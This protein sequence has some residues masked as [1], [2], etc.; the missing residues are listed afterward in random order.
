MPSKSDFFTGREAILNALH[1][2]LKQTGKAALKQAISGLGGIGKTQTAI[3]YAEKFQDEYTFIL[4]AQ[5]ENESSLLDSYGVF[6]NKLGLPQNPNLAERIHYVKA[7]LGREKGWLL[8]CD[9]ADIPELVIQFLPRRFE[10]RVLITS[11]AQIFDTVGITTPVN[12]D[13]LDPDEALDFLKLRTGR[14]TLTDE[15]KQAAQTI[16]EE[17]GYLPLA[18]EQA[19][20]YI[21]AK[22]TFSGYLGILRQQMMKV[23]KGTKPVAGNYKETVATTWLINFQEV[24]TNSSAAVDILRLCAFLAPN[25]IPI[26]LLKNGADQISLAVVEA[27]Q[28]SFTPN[29][30]LEPL[31]KYSLIRFDQKT[32]TFMV[33]RLVQEVIRDGLDEPSQHQWA[34]KTIRLLDQAFPSPETQITLDY[35]DL[36]SLHVIRVSEWINRFGIHSEEAG[37]L[38]NNVGGYLQ[39]MGR[40]GTAEPLCIQAFAIAEK[41]FGPKH[42]NTATALNNIALLKIHKGDLQEVEQLLF[43]AQ[44]IYI[45]QFGS[46][47]HYVARVQSNLASL[48]H[49][50]G[51]FLEAKSIHETVLKTRMKNL[52]PN[53]LET[54]KTLNNLATTLQ[55]L[56]ELTEAEPKFQ[57]VFEIRQTLL[58]KTHPDT[59]ATLINLAIVYHD[60]GKMKEA[61]QLCNQAL[62]IIEVYLPNHPILANLLM[63]LAPIRITQNRVSEAE[64]LYKQAY[65]T[66]KTALSDQHPH[67]QKAKIRYQLLLRQL[68]KNDQI[69]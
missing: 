68:E 18:L 27:F 43:R 12:L 37:G 66:F 56:G 17:L 38:L 48:Y 49:F 44:E 45:Q 6:A 53:H 46:A 16:A 65:S 57:Q 26:E 4:W 69:D 2:S 59:V 19:G 40:F 42:Q 35:K 3:A 28:N 61:E 23:L 67:T 1:Q 52:G 50:Q 29:D 24:E 7:W 9:N 11:R 55:A 15:E 41:I 8:I 30:V 31:T 33:H 32:Q 13:V 58:G 20:A 10:G 39:E 51:R 60:Q 25:P 63:V 64:H 34:E 62:K 54:A 21:L 22:T 14:E 36:L 47:H 5:A